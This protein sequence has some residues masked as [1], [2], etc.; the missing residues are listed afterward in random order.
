[1]RAGR[2]ELADD[3]LDGDVEVIRDLA[4]ETDA[5]CGL[6]I[7]ALAGQEV[8][9]CRPRADLREGE[10]RDHRRDDPE[11]HLGEREQ[12]VRS[13]DRD[14]RDG[15]EAGAT[16]ERVTLDPR[17]DRCGT[18]VDRLEHAAHRVRVRHVLVEGEPDGRTHPVDVGAGAEARTLAGENDSART[19][20]IDEHLRELGDQLCI[21]RVP[22]IGPRQR[23]AK[24]G[25]VPLDAKVRHDA[26]L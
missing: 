2:E 9:P 11:L 26:G 22:P 18:A 19:T 13:A 20:D 5:E 3:S 14:V 8:A 25:P 24:H 1:M 10:R 16:A 12:R 21:E 15:D 7:E 6:R 4:D 17:H 23:D